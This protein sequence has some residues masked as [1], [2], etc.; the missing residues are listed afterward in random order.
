[1]HT[2]HTDLDAACPAVALAKEACTKVR[3]DLKA[4][5]ASLDSADTLEVPIRIVIRVSFW[6]AQQEARALKM[7]QI[8]VFLR[9]H[10]LLN[11][12]MRTA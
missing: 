8:L 6:L 11:I 4:V 5:S 12:V 2:D 1:M 7:Q 3:L 9:V 10:R